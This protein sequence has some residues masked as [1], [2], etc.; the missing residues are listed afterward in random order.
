[1]CVCVYVC[2]VY[3]CGGCFLGSCFFFCGGESIRIIILIEL[4]EKSDLR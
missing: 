2:V 1:M 4:T 3:V